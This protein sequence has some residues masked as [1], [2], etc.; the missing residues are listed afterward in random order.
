M[1]TE[2][3]PSP[4]P[5]RKRKLT[6][7]ETSELASLPDS[8]DALEREREDVYASLADPTLL[9]NGAATVAAKTRLAAIE[10]EIELRISR[11]EELETIA[12]G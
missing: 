3:A 1:R 8:I 6:Y 2:R 9:R 12:A 5:E 4:A 10:S 11:W 7:R